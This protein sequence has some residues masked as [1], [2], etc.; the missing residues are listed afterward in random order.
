MVSAVSM[1]LVRAKAQRQRD[2][3]AKQ[4]APFERLRGRKPEGP[5][6]PDGDHEGDGQAGQNP[7][8]HARGIVMQHQHGEGCDRQPADAVGDL[9]PAQPEKVLLPLQHAGEHRQPDREQQH[10][11]RQ[12]YR[13]RVGRSSTAP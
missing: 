11:Q 5:R 8:H 1:K 9:A 6:R 13:G 7:Q 2:D 4:A 12:P 3:L 10:R